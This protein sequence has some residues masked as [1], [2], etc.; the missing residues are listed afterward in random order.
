MCVLVLMHAKLSNTSY[1]GLA[2]GNIDGDTY[3]Q[4]LLK[5]HPIA[6]G[7]HTQPLSVQGKEDYEKY[8]LYLK[9]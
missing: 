3:V 6:T 9:R 8:V 1:L 5:P 7:A 2:S 4:G